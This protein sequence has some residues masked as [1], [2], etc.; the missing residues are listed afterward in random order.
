MKK[1]VFV[2]LML[3]SVGA[4]ASTW[5]NVTLVD[6]MCARKVKAN[7]D[8]HTRECTLGCAG[9]GLGILTSEGKFLKF[10]KAGNEQASKLLSESDKK[11]RLRVKVDGEQK[12]EIIAVKK[13]EWQ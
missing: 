3:F 5:D 6:S 2:L 9:S 1:I 4:L 13:I 8:A 10:D 12:G 7:P 11:D